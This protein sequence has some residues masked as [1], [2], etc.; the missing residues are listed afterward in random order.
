[1][2]KTIAYLFEYR[3][4]VASSLMLLWV[5]LLAKKN[6][7]SKRWWFRLMP[8]VFVAIVLESTIASPLAISSPKTGTVV[9]PGDS[10]PVK[11]EIHPAFL[12]VLFPSIGVDLPKCWSCTTAPAGITV[13]GVL[14][15]PPYSFEI[16]LP[17]S[18]PN[19]VLVT[20]ATA[21]I[22][23]SRHTALRS[24]FIELVVKS[25]EATKQK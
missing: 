19:G 7:N 18:V 11:I 20:S 3:L 17:K 21:A 10:I 22:A 13:H 4:L 8:L 5:V 9:H 12:S 24:E 14:A 1:M 2:L 15:G 23:G 16:K 25:A 6:P